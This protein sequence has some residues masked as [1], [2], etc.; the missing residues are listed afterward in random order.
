MNKEELLAA[1]A[2]GRRD[3]AGVALFDAYLYRADLR[4]ADLTGAWLQG[5]DLR[6]TDLRSADLID[7]YLYRAD[8][9]DANLSWA[10]LT[11]ANLRDTNLSGA[12]LSGAD[13]RDADLRDADLRDTDLIGAWLQGANLTGAIGFRFAGAPDPVELRQRVAKQIREY[14]ELH[15]QETW[16]ED[17]DEATCGTPCCVA[18]WACRLGGGIRKQSIQTAAIR[19]LHCDGYRIPSFAPDTP[20][21]DILR[22]LTV[23]IK[24]QQ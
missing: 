12:N 17:T 23:P 24:E 1:Y 13:L 16:G 21:E 5:A 8:L 19:L 2:A 4:F 14:P 9:R 10:D 11:C 22:D 20:R 3:F 7:A 6:H 18:G 15:D